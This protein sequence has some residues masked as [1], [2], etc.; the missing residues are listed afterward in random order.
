MPYLQAPFCRV[1][2]A[3]FLGTSIVLQRRHWPRRRESAAGRMRNATEAGQ[4]VDF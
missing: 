1:V 3:A 4:R 2:L